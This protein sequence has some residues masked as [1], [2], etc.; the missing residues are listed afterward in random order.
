M[1]FISRINGDAALFQSAADQA[2]GGFDRA[3][4]APDIGLTS[5][6]FSQTGAVTM[7]PATS[8]THASAL[9]PLPGFTGT[10]PGVAAMLHHGAHLS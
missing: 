8:Q 2:P 4:F 1:Q 3:M 6:L 9:A 5:A 10:L 7:R